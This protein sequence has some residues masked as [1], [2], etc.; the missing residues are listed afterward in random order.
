MTRALAEK[1]L[2]LLGYRVTVDDAR[3]VQRGRNVAAPTAPH[4]LWHELGHAL[5][6]LGDASPRHPAEGWYPLPAWL[7]RL[8]LPEPEADLY[9]DALAHEAA[10]LVGLE[11][12]PG[13]T[14]GVWDERAKLYRRIPPNAREHIER[15]FLRALA[16]A[17]L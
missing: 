13:A 12:A 14:P 9:A 3:V 10:R 7:A 6:Y 5:A 2:G 16:L 1:L 11:G 15:R 4:F 8:E 17:R